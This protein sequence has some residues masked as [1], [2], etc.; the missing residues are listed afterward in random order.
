MIDLGM[1]AFEIR[2][3]IGDKFPDDEMGVIEFIWE[4]FK[5]LY[6]IVLNALS[7]PMKLTLKQSAPMIRDA[8]RLS[9][10]SLARSIDAINTNI[11]EKTEKFGKL[12]EILEKFTS[13]THDSEQAE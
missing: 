13:K 2:E 12:G 1:Q 3:F 7:I 8:I 4:L 9:L 6:T 10:D 5:T 11:L